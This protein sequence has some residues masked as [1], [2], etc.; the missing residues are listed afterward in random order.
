[1]CN[2]LSPSLPS[3]LFE[4]PSILLGTMLSNT[5]NLRFPLEC[6]TASH[7]HKL[8]PMQSHLW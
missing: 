6:K 8:R 5:S 3:F 1:M 2:F 7:P 4:G